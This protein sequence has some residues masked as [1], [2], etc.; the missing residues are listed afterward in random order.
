MVPYSVLP[1][2]TIMQP[3]DPEARMRV[4]AALEIEY[5]RFYGQL[6]CYIIGQLEGM[7]QHYRLHPKIEVRLEQ[8]E[9]GFFKI[10][11]SSGPSPD[12][13][14][15]LTPPIDALGLA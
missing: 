1:Q 8:F 10:A 4:G 14:R 12:A 11:W 2:D 15:R 13:G 7:V 6:D 9:N 3:V 5:R